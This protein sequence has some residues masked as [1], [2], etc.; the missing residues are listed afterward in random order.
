MEMEKKR[1]IIMER[2]IKTMEE[3]RMD[4]VG[5]EMKVQTI[6]AHVQLEVIL[7]NQVNQ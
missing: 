4:K 6:V 1:V 3:K 5:Q 7:G 2:R